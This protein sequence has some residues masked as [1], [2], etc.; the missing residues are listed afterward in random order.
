MGLESFVKPNGGADH[1]GRGGNLLPKMFDHIGAD[2]RQSPVDGPGCDHIGS[3]A[4]GPQVQSHAL[5]IVGIHID[6][7][8]TTTFPV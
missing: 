5:K 2:S 4:Q 6:H 1:L 8:L 7:F 3:S